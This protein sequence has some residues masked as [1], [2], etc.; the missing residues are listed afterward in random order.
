MFQVT[1]DLCFC[2]GMSG[3]QSGGSERD[4][5]KFMQDSQSA[6]SKIC[7]RILLKCPLKYPAVRNMMCL[8][9][10]KMHTESDRCRQKMAL[11]MKFVQDK[12]LS[13]GVTMGNMCRHNRNVNSYVVFSKG[14]LWAPSLNQWF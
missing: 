11:I 13:G 4:V 9:P 14:S 5:L 1:H 6:L 2:Q 7:N 10:Q 12:K 8:D 3:S